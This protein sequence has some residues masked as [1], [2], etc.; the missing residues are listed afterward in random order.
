MKKVPF[1]TEKRL[2]PDKDIWGHLINDDVGYIITR[3]MMDNW[4]VITIFV[5]LSRFVTTSQ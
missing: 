5:G 3:V 1:S 4:C 2:V